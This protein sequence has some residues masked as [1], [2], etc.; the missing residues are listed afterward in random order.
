MSDEYREPC[1][2]LRHTT[3][4]TQDT[5][6]SLEWMLLEA[7]LIQDTERLERERNYFNRDSEEDQ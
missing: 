5:L 2:C 1:G 3:E 7:M 4:I 6:N